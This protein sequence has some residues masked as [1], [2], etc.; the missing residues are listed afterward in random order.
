MLLVYTGER[1]L[2]YEV[3][4]HRE[5]DNGNCEQL[6]HG[7]YEKYRKVQFDT[8]RTYYWSYNLGLRLSQWCSFAAPC[9]NQTSKWKKLC[10][11]KFRL[12]W[13]SQFDISA[14]QDHVNGSYVR[15]IHVKYCGHNYPDWKTVR[16]TFSIRT[17]GFQ[18]QSGKP[19]NGK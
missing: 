1:C 3:L 16:F 17:T 18:C 10:S 11:R 6:V 8:P 5:L 19:T 15:N 12:F 13:G 4:E 14:V 7:T 9:L 2:S